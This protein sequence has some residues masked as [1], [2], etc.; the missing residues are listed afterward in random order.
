MINR[1]LT[2]VAIGIFAMVVIS[3]TGNYFTTVNANTVWTED[4]SEDVV[5]KSKEVGKDV[6][7][8]TKDTGKA[9]GEKTVEGT[10][11]V[12][13]KT[14]G[15]AKTVGAK[16]VDGTKAVVDVTKQGA[17]KTTNVIKKIIPH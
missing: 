3:S 10:G 7:D 17:K 11:M 9:V 8:K 4:K 13:D 6:V 5:D 2:K 1:L 15:T 16:T 12:I 14:T